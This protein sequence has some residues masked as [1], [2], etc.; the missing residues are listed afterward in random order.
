MLFLVHLHFH[1][2]FVI[3]MVAKK[4]ITITI[5]VTTDAL[6]ERSHLLE[7]RQQMEYV[8]NSKKNTNE[9]CFNYLLHVG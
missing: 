5:K 3:V 1:L 6:K 8:S 2:P 7:V 9:N 4:V